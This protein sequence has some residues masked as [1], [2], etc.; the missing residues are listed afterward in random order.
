MLEN[1]AHHAAEVEVGGLRFFTFSSF[2]FYTVKRLKTNF[3]MHW[4]LNQINIIVV[5]NTTFPSC[6]HFFRFRNNFGIEKSSELFELLISI[7]VLITA[8]QK[9]SVKI[10]YLWRSNTHSFFVPKTINLPQRILTL[11]YTIMNII[12]KR[13]NN[14]LTRLSQE[15]VA[16]F[17]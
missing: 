14:W 5:G 8:H 7:P 16:F 3:D 6:A 10:S 13:K 15:I 17:N 9:K 12:R 1:T 11:I 4:P 2:I